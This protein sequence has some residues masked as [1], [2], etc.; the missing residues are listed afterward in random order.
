MGPP[1][2]CS[3]TIGGRT[4]I[5]RGNRQKGHRLQRNRGDQINVSNIPFA[6]DVAGGETT[7]AENRWLKVLKNNQTLLLNLLLAFLVFF[8]I[9]KPFMRKFQEMAAEQK[10]LP[11]LK[12]P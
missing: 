4:E 3:W 7:A 11:A 9:V 6:T 5:H 10:S 12:T 8:F 2:P 1:S